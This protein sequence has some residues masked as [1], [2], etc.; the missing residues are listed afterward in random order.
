MERLNLLN[1]QFASQETAQLSHVAQAPADPILS[2][3]IGFKNDKDANKVNLGVGAYRTEEGKPL[4]FPV[5]REAEA[6]IVANKTLDKEYLPIDG[7]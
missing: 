4:V 3:S 2:L 5:V 1:T 6:Q 7:D